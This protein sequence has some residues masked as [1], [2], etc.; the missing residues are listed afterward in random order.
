MMSQLA[1]SSAPIFPQYVPQSPHPRP[2]G[3]TPSVG[4]CPT[5]R[6]TPHRPTPT[7]HTSSHAVAP[8][9]FACKGRATTP[10]RS[11][12]RPNQWRHGWRPRLDECRA[13]AAAGHGG[14][15]ATQHHIPPNSTPAHRRVPRQTPTTPPRT[16]SPPA[17]PRVPTKHTVGTSVRERPT[18]SNGTVVP[19]TRPLALPTGAHTSVSMVGPTRVAARPRGTAAAATAGSGAGAHAPR[20]PGRACC[21]AAAAADAA[22]ARA[23]TAAAATKARPMVRGRVVEALPPVVPREPDLPLPSPSRTEGGA[24]RG[25]RAA[26]TAVCEGGCLWRAGNGVSVD[27]PAPFFFFSPPP[28]AAPLF[29]HGTKPTRRRHA[30]PRPRPP[31]SGAAQRGGPAVP[32]HPPRQTP[33]PVRRRRPTPP[34]RRRR[35]HDGGRGAAPRGAAAPPRRRAA[36]TKPGGARAE[37]RATRPAPARGPATAAG[38]IARARDWGPLGPVARR[39]GSPPPARPHGTPTRRGGARGW[40]GR[41]G[42]RRRAR[43]RAPARRRAAG[44]RR[45]GGWGDRPAGRRAAGDAPRDVAAAPRQPGEG[46]GGGSGAHRRCR[47]ARAPAGAPRGRPGA[48][49]SA[50]CGATVGYLKGDARSIGGSG[51]G[52]QAA[53]RAWRVALPSSRL[54]HAPPP[55]PPAP[56][57][58]ATAST[59]DRSVQ[60]PVSPLSA[61]TRASSRAAPVQQAQEAHWRR[62]AGRPPK[63]AWWHSAGRPVG[64]PR[65]P[66][67]LQLLW[68]SPLGGRAPPPPPPPPPTVNV[69]TGGRRPPT[70]GGHW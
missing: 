67:R 6:T 37:I 35:P 11:G 44:G 39:G 5:P 62:A 25:A 23:P 66:W 49:C 52:C 48:G 2:P 50:A 64:R 21:T 34:P 68:G 14:G 56:S 27:P 17:L 59:V 12:W 70:A 16:L 41:A 28:P 3:A 45:A 61:A 24:S 19:P 30:P 8:R 58:S 22:P 55:P 1:Q 46:A 38:A 18:A 9:H 20:K 53:T 7:G 51:G 63:H 10:T 36:R 40:R 33:H 54:A 31:P 29:R 26:Q 32:L 60:R 57:A 4:T 13:H 65:R 15:S 42:G 47:H 43:R 69:P